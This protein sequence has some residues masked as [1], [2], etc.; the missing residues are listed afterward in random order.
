MMVKVTVMDLPFAQV[1]LTYAIYA[2]ISRRR[3]AAIKAGD[4]TVSQFRE[5]QDE[6]PQ[7]R[8][9]RNNLANQFELPVLFFVLAALSALHVYWAV[10]GVWPGSD[11]ASCAR[12][13]IGFRGVDGMP[14]PASAF[15]VA[16]LLGVAAVLAAMLAGAPV[17]LPAAWLAPAV[18]EAV[19]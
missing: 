18:P 17:L 6:P 19:V 8:F 12:T 7:S 1:A 13:V 15:A 9:V 4:A 2:L 11:A 14:P 16:G 10:G 5:N 3:V